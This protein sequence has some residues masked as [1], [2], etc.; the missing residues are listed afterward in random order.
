MNPRLQTLKYLIS[1]F[2]AATFTWC[3]FYVFRKTH[4]EPLKFGYD[5][6]ISLDYKFYLGLIVIPSFW[7][8]QYYLIGY[9]HDVYR[10]S[11]LKELG[12]TFFTTLFGSIVLFFTIILDDTIGS[13]KNYYQSFGFLFSLQFL[14]T[15]LPRLIITTRTTH[16]LHKRLIG[17]KTL[18]IGS[19]RIALELFSE[20]ARARRS[21]GNTFVGFV[22]IA[23]KPSYLMS[24]VLPHLGGFGEIADIIAREQVEE[25][26]LAAEEAEHSEISRI[27][28]KLEEFKVIVKV[29]PSMYDILT[30]KVKMA[31]VNGAPIIQIS[32]ELLPAWQ[33]NLKRLI[34]IVLSF[35]ALIFLLPGFLVIA[36]GVKFSSPGPIFYS[37]Q[38]IGRYGK[39]FLI[40]KFRSMVANAEPNGP[41]LSSQRDTRVT[42]FGRILR[43]SRLDELPQFFNVLIGDM[44]LVGPRPER[45]FF[46]DQIIIKAPHY[47]HLHKVRPGITSWGQ[48]KYG[49]A[50]NVKEMI[51]RLKY[52][53]VYIENMSLYND[54]KI[55]IY[56][57]KT[58]L[59][60]SGK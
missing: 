20:M 13:Y 7:L 40:Y 51:A 48:V 19:S 26:I 47:V 32:H 33:E 58:I 11:R 4:I 45:Q 22:H 53:L 44:S 18:I 34:D 55:L 25:I 8:L 16:R 36:I 52:D 38:R 37:H 54:F 17:F 60:G 46:I 2:L 12:Q 57:I 59:E 39:P 14:T 29:I 24:R 23:P 31:L 28:N 49:Y 5:I 43:K 15:Y 1:D 10:K 30:G 41:A 35:L 6:P 9:Y 50:E 42:P 3:L 56:T 27:L 21:S